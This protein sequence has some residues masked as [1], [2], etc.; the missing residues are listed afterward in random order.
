VTLQLRSSVKIHSGGTAMV[1]REH[2]IPKDGPL[3]LSIPVKK[4]DLDAVVTR[5]SVLGNVMLPEPPSYPPSNINPTELNF[6][7]KNVT[8][9]L[10]IKLRGAKVK[11][12][13]VGQ[14]DLIG[15]LGGIQEYTEGLQDGNATV[16][17]W[18][19]VV[20]LNTGE[21]K[22][23]RKRKEVARFETRNH[24]GSEERA[25]REGGCPTRGAGVTDGFVG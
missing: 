4:R 1:T 2:R 25:S 21:I 11:I 23:R 18:R 24:P 8:K 19:V 17:R 12:V 20:V 7:P 10:A 14:G 5:L 6:D 15:T 22:T 16:E 9:D 13:A 3:K